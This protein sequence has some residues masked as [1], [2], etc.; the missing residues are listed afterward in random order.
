MSALVRK[1]YIYFFDYNVNGACIK[2]GFSLV[3]E[4]EL[5]LVHCAGCGRTASTY[6]S[7][8]GSRI[9]SST[10]QEARSQVL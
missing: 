7:T 6:I 8:L 2:N 3:L 4:A 10:A 5:V 1:K 9:R